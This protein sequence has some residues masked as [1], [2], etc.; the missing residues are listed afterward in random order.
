LLP[1]L[2]RD[3]LAV[4]LRRRKVICLRLKPSLC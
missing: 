3:N 4:L 1:K 2:S